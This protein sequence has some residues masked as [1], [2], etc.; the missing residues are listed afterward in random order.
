MK[1][2]PKIDPKTGEQ[3]VGKSVNGKPGRPIWVRLNQHHIL[4]RAHYPE[5]KFEP[6]NRVTLCPGCHKHSRF[7]AHENPVHFVLWLRRH[8]LE[9][10][11][12]CRQHVGHHPK[13]PDQRPWHMAKN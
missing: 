13:D 1:A 10:Y 8:K 11:L 6:L 4:S 12:W 9:S 5:L 2:H 7:S 3:K